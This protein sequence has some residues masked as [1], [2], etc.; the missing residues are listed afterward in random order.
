M[1]VY[2]SPYMQEA[3]GDT[4]RPGG[5][6]LTEEAVRFCALS[7]RDRILDVG[8]GM[9]ATVSYLYHAYGIK[10]VGI[11]PSEKLLEKARQNNPFASFVQG[12]GHDLP[13]DDEMFSCVFAE[14]TLSLMHDLQGS[15]DEIYRVLAHGGWFVLNDVYAKNPEALKA[16]DNFSV[17][18]CMRGMHDLASLQQALQR[19]GFDVM[20]VEDCSVLLKELMVKIIFSHGSMSTFWSKT[21]EDKTAQTSCS[22]DRRITQC[23]PGYFR[24]IVKKGD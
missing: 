23:K 17:T 8:C 16:M 12:F 19:A 2:E 13:F 20:L 18:S 24:M 10:T 9:G 1:N 22:F 6:T 11:D 3:T 4:L 14:C 5:F 7:K 21:M 15:L